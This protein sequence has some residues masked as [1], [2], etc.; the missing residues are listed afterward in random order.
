MHALG[1]DI[2][3]IEEKHPLD[4]I[5]PCHHLCYPYVLAL[6]TLLLMPTT[7]G[8]DGAPQKVMIVE[9]SKLKLLWRCCR[10]RLWQQHSHC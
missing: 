3:I 9:H 4:S 7:V 10:P 8:Q 5:L 2:M 6:T 1:I